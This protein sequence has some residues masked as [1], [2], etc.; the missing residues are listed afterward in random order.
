MSP[1]VATFLFEL[2]NVLL[3]AGLLSWLLFKPVRAALQAK[4]DA[5]RQRREA[6][7]AQEAEI[8]QQRGDLDQRLRAFE[9][10]IAEAR[11]QR[12]AAATQEGAAIRQAAHEVAERERESARRALAQLERA[13]VERLSAAVASVA[14]ESVARLLAS[15]DG[16]DLDM[17]LARV[18]CSQLATLDRRTL[19]AVL[20]ESAHPLDDSARAAVNVVLDGQPHAAQFRVVPDLG[21]G[22]RIV[23][24]KGLIDASARG[25]AKEAE[26][27]LADSLAVDST[28]AMT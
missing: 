1:T 16:H 4:Q 2:I 21:A 6:L 23:T 18:A 19:G 10:D 26:R 17:S 11:Q 3:L 8:A 5:E 9:T 20:V 28:G 12:L 13:H 15:V 24:S 27:L 14:R 7:L 22:L 25:I